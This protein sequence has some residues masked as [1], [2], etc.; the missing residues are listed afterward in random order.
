M[1]GVEVCVLALPLNCAHV[2]RSFTK[3]T[4]FDD[5]VDIIQ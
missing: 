3:R 4:L 5:I 1:I 2:A